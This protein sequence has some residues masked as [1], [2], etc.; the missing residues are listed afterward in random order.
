MRRQSLR[1][2]IDGAGSVATG[3]ARGM[4]DEPRDRKSSM[5]AHIDALEGLE[6]ERHVERHAVIARAAPNP[7][8]DAGQLGALAH[9]RPAPRASPA[10][11]T[12]KL[13]D[14]GDDGV[15][16]R[17]HQFAHAQAAAPQVQ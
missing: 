4:I 9:T 14:V 8:A 7:Q 1:R 17:H 3:K 16:E 15:L 13:G 11:S 10:P 6:I 12:P 5:P 2:R